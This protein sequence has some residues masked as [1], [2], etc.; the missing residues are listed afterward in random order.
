MEASAIFLKGKMITGFSEGGNVP[1]PPLE[2][3]FDLL[4]PTQS[5]PNTYET[6]SA[7]FRGRVAAQLRRIYAAVAE[8]HQVEL[9]R[10]H[11]AE[12]K[13][14]AFIASR[15][16]EQ[17]EGLTAY[18]DKLGALTSTGKKRKND[19]YRL[20]QEYDWVFE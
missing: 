16:P 3:F 8:R 4:E 9:R 15:T 17:L 20:R 5:W 1:I 13:K 10:R 18:Q 12:E 14:K 2:F 19:K 6:S 7:Q 11:E